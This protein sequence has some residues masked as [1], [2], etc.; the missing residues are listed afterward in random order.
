MTVTAVGGT[1]LVSGAGALAAIDVSSMNNGSVGLVALTNDATY[2]DAI[3]LYVLKSDGSA[4]DLPIVIA[5]STPVG[6]K[7]WHIASVFSMESGSDIEAKSLHQLV[8]TSS[9]GVG[10]GGDRRILAVDASGNQWPLGQKIISLSF[11]FILPSS[12]PGDVQSKWVCWNNE[13]GMDFV[14]TRIIT[15]ASV[16][17]QI[18]LNEITSFSNHTVLNQ[19]ATIDIDTSGTGTFHKTITSF[20]SNVIE[21]M[22]GLAV[23]FNSG[24]PVQGNILLQ[25][26]LRSRDII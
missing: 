7:C 26:W 1:S 12:W 21:F 2:G 11:P 25:G 19:I 18:T 10:V 20:D 9:G 15:N 6:D 16:A 17:T 3:L 5:P 13:T 24:E 22:R 4:Q 14:I 23:S 8:H